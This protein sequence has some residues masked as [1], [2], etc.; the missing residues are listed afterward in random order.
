MPILFCRS[1]MLN[2]DTDSHGG[3]QKV[4]EGAYLVCTLSRVTA[5]AYDQVGVWCVRMTIWCHDGGAL[6]DQSRVE[7][8]QRQHS[9]MALLAAREL[10]SNLIDPLYIGIVEG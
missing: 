5:A 7:L 6:Q 8:C 9:S 1:S 10:H 3:W 4:W 2:G